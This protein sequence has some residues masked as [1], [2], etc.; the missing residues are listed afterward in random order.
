MSVSTIMKLVPRMQEIKLGDVKFRNT[1]SHARKGI[2][3]G[4]YVR[5]TNKIREL[6]AS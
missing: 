6:L 2:M 4:D 5:N 1:D 3:E